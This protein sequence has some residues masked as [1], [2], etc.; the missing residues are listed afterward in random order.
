ML[1]DCP[2][3]LD[4][5][6]GDGIFLQDVEVF[7]GADR[8]PETI[9]LEYLV[10]EGADA[11]CSYEFTGTVHRDKYII[12]DTRGTEPDFQAVR[13]GIETPAA[14][15]RDIIN[16]LQAEGLIKLDKPVQFMPR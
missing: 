9:Q 4:D 11:R 16:Y 3:M 1:A 7:H 13:D 5:K 14:V 10:D 2:P 6:V 15:T 8:K 12:G